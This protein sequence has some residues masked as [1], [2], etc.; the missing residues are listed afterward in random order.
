MA[1]AGMAA[2]NSGGTP[3]AA[4]VR[5]GALVSLRADALAASFLLNLTALALPVVLLQLYDRIIPNAA[6]GTLGALLLGLGVAIL[7]E[8]GLRLARASI[9]AWAAAR[10]EHALSVAAIGRI[11]GADPN[12]PGV[13]PAVQADRLAAIGEWRAHRVGDLAWAL[14]DLPF[15]LIYLGFLAWL[16][17]LLALVAAVAA[18]PCLAAALLL[19]PAAHRAIQV[20]TLAEQHRHGLTHEIIA[21]IEPIKALGAE[22]AMLRRHDR[23]VAAAAAAGR[24]TTV[25]TQLCAA[26]AASASQA[27]VAGLALVGAWLA[28]HSQ[29][30]AGGLAAAILLGARGVEPLARLA[31]SGPALARATASRQRIREVLAQPQ[32]RARGAD[33]GRLDS[34]V[35][36]GV[37]L[38]HPADP[39]RPLLRG[40]S[41]SLGIGQCIAIQGGGGSG[42]SLLLQALLGQ[43]APQAGRILVNGWP[44]DTLDL[45][46]VRAQV[47]L[48]AQHPALLPGRVIDN[49]TRFEPRFTEAAL[50][51]SVELGLDAWFARHPVGTAMAVGRSDG[52]DLPA[53]VAE[54]VAAVRAL[55]R[56]PRLILFD[57]ANA[58]QDRDGDAR[59]R[60]LLERLKPTAMIVLVSHRPSWLAMADQTFL[61]RDGRL[62]PQ[63]SGQSRAVTSA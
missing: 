56:R 13:A 34:L 32:R 19:T 30:S 7:L 14:A 35:L 2:G 50:A 45:E 47:A 4:S 40:V 48:L 29:L 62:L 18:L 16:S 36:E 6:L 21:G 49:M 10:E 53:S 1:L 60:A 63:A 11:L 3:A 44:I 22:A 15:V 46:R 41:F 12:A 38:A 23:L 28:M 31:G 43:V 57:E 9:A 42:K 5:V 51:L 58:A 27:V 8:G 17:P 52:Q 26:L 54:R 55:V 61:L 25:L 39:A 24:R 20:R 33:P 37:S 59:M